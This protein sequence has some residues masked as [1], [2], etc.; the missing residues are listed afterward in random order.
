[1]EKRVL[2][3][4]YE[5]PPLGGG[6]G[7]AARDLAMGLIEHGYKI[8][9]VTSRFSGA[10]VRENVQGISVYRVPSFRFKNLK[11]ASYFSMLAYLIFGTVCAL[12][13]IIKNKYS[14]INTHFVVPTGPL[15]YLVSKLGRTP[16]VLTM[17]GGDI[18]DPTKKRS[19]HK[20]ALLRPII[21]FLI[22]SA[23][24]VI[25]E[26]T[27]IKRNALKYYGPKSEIHII[28][29]PYNIKEF[30]K[31]ERVDLG[32]EADKIYL[33]S[34]GRLVKRKGFDQLIRAMKFVKNE[35]IRCQII[36]TGP[37]K[38][39]LRDLVDRLGV[40]NKV[41]LLGYIESE[42]KKFQIL[43]KSDIYVLPSI[44]EGFGVVLQEACRQGCQ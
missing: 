19:P 35:D 31:A 23:D 32:M 27:E 12:R 15:G 7:V 21:K 39:S 34:V 18:Y 24:V 33:V 11:T 14:F 41:K 37:E 29:L 16:N 10:K 42:E 30:S 26:S 2:I 8:D 44:H 43:E 13:L 4:N 5:F 17:L 38:D 28:P 22:D 25:T 1:M 36:G 6:G 40:R 3:L 9:Y 20:F